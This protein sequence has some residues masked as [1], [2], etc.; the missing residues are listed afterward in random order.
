MA[1]ASM[2][3]QPGSS[4]KAVWPWGAWSRTVPVKTVARPLLQVLPTHSGSPAA[5][6]ISTWAPAPGLTIWRT[7]TAGGV[8]HVALNGGD[9]LSPNRQ[10]RLQRRIPDQL[11]AAH[12]ILIEGVCRTAPRR[13]QSPP[14]WRGRSTHGNP[15]S[16]RPRGPSAR[17]FASSAHAAHRPPT[18]KRIFPAHRRTSQAS[19]GPIRTE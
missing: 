7:I 11:F 5:P 10:G 8:F 4:Q 16:P 2:S 6:A 17:R 12:V 19:F 9:R 15:P 3:F 1:A 18:S 13:A 14:R